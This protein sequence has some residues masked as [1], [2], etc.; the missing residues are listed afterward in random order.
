M[1]GWGSLAARSDPHTPLHHDA[2]GEC[3]SVFLEPL[4]WMEASD[5]TQGHTEGK[6]V[7]R[8]VATSRARHGQ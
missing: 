1:V 7:C 8:C 5:V 3:T 4:S 2:A 6:L